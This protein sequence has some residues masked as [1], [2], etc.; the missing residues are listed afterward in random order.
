MAGILPP[1]SPSYKADFP[2]LY[3][4]GPARAK[5]LLAEAGYP[6]GFSFT[7]IATHAPHVRNFTYPARIWHDFKRVCFERDGSPGLDAANRYLRCRAGIRFRL[8]DRPES[9][10][11]ERYDHFVNS[12]D[13]VA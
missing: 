3:P 8:F 13:I 10:N 6:D 11:D 1:A 9:P 5:A 12:F 2:E 7:D 4:H